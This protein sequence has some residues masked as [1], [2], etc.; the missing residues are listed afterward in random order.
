MPDGVKFIAASRAQ[1]RIAANVHR[2]FVSLSLSLSVFFF[3]FFR[4]RV[5]GR[6][7]RMRSRD[8]RTYL[9]ARENLSRRDGRY[10]QNA[11]AIDITTGGMHD[12]RVI[13]NFCLALARIAR[14]IRLPNGRIRANFLHGRCADP[15]HANS[16]N[17]FNLTPLIADYI[18]RRLIIAPTP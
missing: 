4:G 18:S 5:G 17:K 16:V 3:F 13:S 14:S 15:P 2:S 6:G 10:S 9:R 8:P 1:S 12:D 11:P 7:G